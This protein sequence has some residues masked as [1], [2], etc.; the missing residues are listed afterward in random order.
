LEEYPGETCVTDTFVRCV[1]KA[2]LKGFDFKRIWPLPPGTNYRVLHN[3]ER[4]KREKAELPPARTLIGNSVLIRLTLKSAEPTKAET[5]RIEQVMDE[6]DA[7]TVDKTSEAPAVGNLEGYEY[8]A[9]ECWLSLSAPDADALVEKLRPWLKALDW[10][11]GFKVL[12]RYGEHY[13]D[14]A[15][16]V[17]VKSLERKISGAAARPE[18]SKGPEKGSELFSSE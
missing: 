2:A 4:K 7:V 12:K 15:P 6:L 18:K 3:Q 5:Q 16:T 10:P 14:D 8:K 17:Q 9:G 1:Q 13:Q 11:S